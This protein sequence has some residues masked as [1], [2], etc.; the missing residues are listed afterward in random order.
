MFKL[1][2]KHSLKLSMSAKITFHEKQLSCIWVM[3]QILES[4][5]QERMTTLIMEHI[6]FVNKTPLWAGI[7]MPVSEL[8]LILELM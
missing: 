5:F 3:E 4:D 7:A 6:V 8:G 1:L 2:N